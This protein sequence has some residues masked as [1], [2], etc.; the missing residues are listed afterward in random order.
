M[1]ATKSA[2]DAERTQMEQEEMPLVLATVRAYP[3]QQLSR[4]TADFWD[5]V[6]HFGVYGFESE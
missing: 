3:L 4:S 1:A 5:Q 2:S 6:L